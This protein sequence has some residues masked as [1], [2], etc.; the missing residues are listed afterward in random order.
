[1]SIYL[2]FTVVTFPI[3]VHLILSI[4]ENT[5]NL[6]SLDTE[7]VFGETPNGNDNQSSQLMSLIYMIYTL[8]RAVFNVIFLLLLDNY[9]SKDQEQ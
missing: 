1:M 6:Y 7:S 8:I 3:Q 2:S 4:L 5:L 9:V